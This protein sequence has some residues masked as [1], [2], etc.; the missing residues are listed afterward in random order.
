MEV[1]NIFSFS[2]I[3]NFY[4]N[5]FNAS[6]RIHFD[7]ADPGHVKI[8]VFDQLG[9]KVKTLCNNQLDAGRYSYSWKG[10]DDNGV[11]V[12]SGA[13]FCRV[14]TGSENEIIKMVVIK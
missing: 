14:S 4:P 5:P 1:Y 11:L 3:F 7:L 13:Y 10:I 12:N 2:I 6:T 9:R 8:I